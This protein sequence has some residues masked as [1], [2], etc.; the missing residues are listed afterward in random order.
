MTPQIGD[1][2]QV[3]IGNAYLLG[4]VKFSTDYFIA[5]DQGTGVTAILRLDPASN[6]WRFG[7]QKVT[8]SVP[9]TFH[10]TLLRLL[11]LAIA[12]RYE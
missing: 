6:C 5:I 7:K 3:K 2:I 12:N 4:R 1:A 10:Q 11:A 9:E 8:W